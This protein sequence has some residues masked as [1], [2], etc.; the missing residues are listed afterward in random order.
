MRRVIYVPQYP[1]PLRYQ[2]W[3]FDELPKEFK[4]AGFEVIILGEKYFETTGGIVGREIA[5]DEMFSPINMAIT[6]ETEQIKEY[7]E[8]ELNDDDILFFSDI[9]FPGFFAHALYHKKPKKCY[10]FCHATSKNNL[11]YFAKVHYSKFH[12]E[13]ANAMMFN[14]VFVASYY[15]ERKIHWPNAVITR[16]PYPPL[17]SMKVPWKDKYYDIISASR[18]TPQK[19]DLDLEAKVGKA[20]SQVNRP[21]ADSWHY[22]FKNLAYSKVLL[23]TSYEDTFGYQIVDAVMNGCIPIAPNRCAYPE[24]LPRE[25]LYNDENELF[26]ILWYALTGN[27]VVPQ[28]LCHKEMK[29]FYKSIIE[30][31]KGE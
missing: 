11:D 25:Y 10:A 18:P 29:N 8:L 5:P 23:I 13:E 19:V 26:E 9:S 15:H 14:K 24:I 30:E 12:V 27:M 2:E 17:K 22:Y 3:W 16:L 28:L 6:F 20:F 31:I 4:K 1:T 21:V 7:M